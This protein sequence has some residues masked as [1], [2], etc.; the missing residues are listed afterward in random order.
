LLSCTGTG[1]SGSATATLSVN[2]ASKSGGGGF[3]G[4]DLLGL[5]LIGLGRRRWR[6]PSRTL[7]RV[8]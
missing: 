8:H 6:G 3:S 2:A 4:W 7:P 1:G 5:G